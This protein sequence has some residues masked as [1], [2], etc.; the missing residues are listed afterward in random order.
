[1]I[2]PRRSRFPD[3][4]G[5]RSTLGR[6]LLP[7]ARAWLR[8]PVA[9]HRHAGLDAIASQEGCRRSYD[10]DPSEVMPICRYRRAC[11]TDDVVALVEG[12]AQHARRF[13]REHH[14][15]VNRNRPDRAPHGTVIG[16][17]APGIPARGSAWQNSQ[18]RHLSHAAG[19]GVW[20]APRPAAVPQAF[21][22]RGVAS[23][24]CAATPPQRSPGLCCLLRIRICSALLRADAHHRELHPA[25][26]IPRAELI[27]SACSDPA[28]MSSRRTA[29]ADRRPSAPS[30][31]IAAKT[32]CF[33]PAMPRA[34]VGVLVIEAV[35]RRYPL[36]IAEI[37]GVP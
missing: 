3:F 35:V 1:M 37:R 23:A 15:V 13:A 5:T 4:I 27:L 16:P 8:F 14:S 19:L 22:C 32:R 10:R 26:S 28:S 24:M 11:R 30:P 7:R 21:L 2:V 25:G 18:G 34:S 33:A 6:T 29:A 9:L 36:R 31:R 12:V 20:Q 17:D